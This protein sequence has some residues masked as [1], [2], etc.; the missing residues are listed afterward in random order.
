MDSRDYAVHMRGVDLSPA[1]SNSMDANLV[2]REIT[3]HFKYQTQFW[4]KLSELST[5]HVTA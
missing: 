1:A 4:Y 2:R 3:C 5:R